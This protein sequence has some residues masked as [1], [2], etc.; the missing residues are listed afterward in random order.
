MLFAVEA[1]RAVSD[2]PIIALLAFLEDGH[3]R[4]E[5]GRRG[6]RD[7]LA[8]GVD[9]IG[10]NCSVGPNLYGF[11]RRNNAWPKSCTSR[12]DRTRHIAT[13]PNA[14]WP[15]HVEGRFIFSSSPELSRA[16]RGRG[17]G[18]RRAH[19]R[20]LLRHDAGTHPEMRQTLDHSAVRSTSSFTY[21]SPFPSI[22]EFDDATE[23]APTELKTKLGKEF[24]ICVEIDPP[25]GI[26]PTKALEGARLLRMPA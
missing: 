18:R 3:T 7:L 13:M 12:T 24:V 8:L 10:A 11:D 9:V 26:N 25:K 17:V 20:W 15:E 5:R 4:P 1:V 6:G 2:L 14:G 19:R 22:Y 16:V 23:R 21:E